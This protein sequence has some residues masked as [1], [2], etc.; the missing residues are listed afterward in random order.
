[1]K[2]RLKIILLLLFV[3]ISTTLS[4]LFTVTQKFYSE[5]TDSVYE[6]HTFTALNIASQLDQYIGKLELLSRNVLPQI[7]KTGFPEIGHVLSIKDSQIDTIYT[8]RKELKSEHYSSILQ[9]SFKPIFTLENFICF[10]LFIEDEN[11]VY[12]VDSNFI[13]KLGQRGQAVGIGIFNIQDFTVLNI[14]DDSFKFIAPDKEILNNISKGEGVFSKII[15]LKTGRML[16]AIA[17]IDKNRQSFILI[18]AMQ[19]QI[20]DLVIS[21]LK[22]MFIIVFVLLLIIISI[23]VF[24]A[25]KLVAPIEYLTKATKQLSQGIWK[26]DLKVNGA[27]EIGELTRSFSEMGGELEKREKKIKNINN[28][29]IQTEKLAS[30]GLFSAGIAHEVKNPLGAILGS[31]QLVKRKSENEDITRYSEMII[32]ESYRAN[33]IIQDLL[34]FAK[35]KP[36]QIVEI[37]LSKF[38]KKIQSIFDGVCKEKGIELYIKECLGHYS[39]DHDQMIQVIENIGFNALDA[40]IESN[41][42][43]LRLQIRFEVLDKRLNVFIE[44][45][46]IGMT[47][48]IK[49][50]IY[51]PF[52]STKKEKKGTGLGMAICFGIIQKH[53]GEII[54]NSKVGEG[55]QFI[56]KV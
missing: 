42:A 16:M 31:A 6:S 40:M 51:E 5:T 38:S 1:M 10:S 33:S 26:L 14:G 20:T 27:D 55:S 28:K 29:L 17:G 47:E 54:I 50:K 32:E 37:D 23:G 3:V 12:M 46:G 45:N 30:L 13:R 56:L 43:N 41:K 11:F 7:V 34:V 21:T 9:K 25:N 15:D 39:F 52:Y 4:V 44:D 8:K 19:T 2:I 35:E 48:E 24:M 53:E 36:L 22:N 49:N 18:E